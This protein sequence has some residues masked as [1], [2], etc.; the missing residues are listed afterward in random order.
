M[1]QL[2]EWL[3][4]TVFT[5]LSPRY[6][7]APSQMVACVRTNR[8]THQRE[9]VALKWKLVPPWA[10]D[11]GIGNRLINA[12]GETV[13]EKPAFRKSIM[14]RHCLI[15][16]DGFYEWKREGQAKHPYYIRFQ[17]GR[18]LLLRDYGTGGINQPP[19]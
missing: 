5:S 10:K 16:A 13:A 4:L 11:P 6:N 18:P 15:L 14:Q 19:L 1:Q 12:R 3:G 2:A 8:E 17:D 9:Y 7:I